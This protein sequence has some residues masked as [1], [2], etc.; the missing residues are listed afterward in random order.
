MRS[1]TFGSPSALMV[2]A[3]SRLTI[4]AGVPAGANSVRWSPS[5]ASL[6]SGLYFYRISDGRRSLSGKMMLMR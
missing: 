1:F 3:E 6:S 2:S 5:E 4:S